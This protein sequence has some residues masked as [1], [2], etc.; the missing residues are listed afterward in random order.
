MVD[1][2]H[3]G[4]DA[5]ADHCLRRV[6]EFPL[7]AMSDHNVTSPSDVACMTRWLFH[8]RLASS[9]CF[10]QVVPDQY[11]TTTVPKPMSALGW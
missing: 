9:V 2:V 5:E 6:E 4:E 11:I 1:A 8:G 10:N 7:W 3:D